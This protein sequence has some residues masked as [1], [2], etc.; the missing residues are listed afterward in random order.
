MP[1]RV[2]EVCN[3]LLEASRDPAEIIRQIRAGPL[4]DV[5]GQAVK[6]LSHGAGNAGK[7][8]GISA[9]TDGRPHCTFPVRELERCGESRRHRARNRYIKTAAAAERPLKPRPRLSARSGLRS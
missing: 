3:R 6:G 4:G 2:T 8:I 1:F 7:R 5:I 9:E